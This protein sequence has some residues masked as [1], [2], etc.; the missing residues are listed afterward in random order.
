MTDTLPVNGQIIGETERSLAPLIGAILAEAGTNFPTW[1][2]L[3]VLNTDGEAVPATAL[4][5]T[6]A[7]RL[8]SD[9]VSI[10]ELL[11]QLESRGL[12]R[13]A[14]GGGVV[15]TA[16]G[17][18]LYQRVREGVERTNAELYAG[19]DPGDLATTRRVLVEVTR[20]ARARVEHVRG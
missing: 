18:A 11:E 1:V 16:D 9:N 20:R 14:P 5:D 3:N 10:P 6:L 19:L 15:L 8:A 13:T 12:A 2:A 7:A 17:R 4:R